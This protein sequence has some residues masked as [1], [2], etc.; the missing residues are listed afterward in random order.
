[1]GEHKAGDKG[2]SMG[3]GSRPFVGWEGKWVHCIMVY[4]LG[5]IS[6]GGESAIL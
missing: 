4:G 2:L 1:M 3:V 5:V 6:G